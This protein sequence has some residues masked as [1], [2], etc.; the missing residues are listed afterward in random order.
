VSGRIAQALAKLSPGMLTLLSALVIGALVLEAWI[1]VLRQPFAA[2]RELSAAR[3]SL[4]AIEELMAAQELELR[5]ASARH[6]ELSQRLGAEL[7]ETAPEEQLTVSLMRKLD[8]AA[9]R[10][11]IKLTSLKPAGHRPV[12]SFEELSF[13]VGAQGKYLALCQWLLGFEELIG[14]FATVSELTMRSVE[15]GKQVSLSLRLALYRPL[16]AGTTLP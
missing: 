5:Q 6:K 4:R 9:S 16:P 13:E 7:G 15:D 12:L 2:Y 8:Q 11:G 10:A 3:Q 14:K 1:L